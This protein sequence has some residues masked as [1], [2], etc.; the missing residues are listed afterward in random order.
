MWKAVAVAWLMGATVSALPAQDAALAAK[1]SQARQD[2]LSGHYQDA[3]AIYRQLVSALPAEPRLRLNL[4]LALVKAGEPNAA[5]PE[6]Q[7]VTRDDPKLGAAW[8][9]LGLAYA[10]L[11]R[12]REAISPLREAVRLDST[13]PQALF[14][15]ADAEL[16]SGAIEE[17]RRHFS[18][19]AGQKPEMAKAWEGLG[20]SY[21]AIS[22]HAVTD[23]KNDDA[24][25]AF[26]FALRGRARATNGDTA[27]AIQ[28]YKRA[29]G[30]D[31]RI[32]GL[33]AALASL[34]RESDQSQEAAKEDALEAEV[35]KP[36][37]HSVSAVCLY[38]NHDWA[39]V[40][41]QR[42][43][44]ASAENLYWASLAAGDL[45]QESFEHLSKLSASGEVHDL[46]AQA[47]QRSGKR[48]EAISEWRKA[49][50]LDP[51]NSR[52]QG[53][54]AESL[55]RARE[56]PEAQRLFEQLVKTEPENP[57]W[58]YFLGSTLQREDRDEEARPFLERAA[59]LEPDFL[60]AQENLGRVYLKLGQLDKA[61]VCLERAGPLDDD[62]SIA[63]ALSAAYRKLGRAEAARNALQKY[64]QLQQKRGT[65][66]P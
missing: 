57:D 44:Q 65:A 17:A 59:Q 31:P 56:Y 39:G 47:D 54:L 27:G 13:N 6:L 51:S 63:F 66:Q 15:L 41:S 8:F 61:V 5:I 46:L 28:L 10:Q 45:A 48:L 3:A 62:G 34:E 49:L 38:V 16:S 19:L 52:L 30:L 53:R 50:A 14:E 11:K 7:R 43:R 36:D 22:E 9:L 58:Q 60:P 32:P 2:M 1:S 21:L 37:C 18:M 40:L 4:A 12:P 20:L 42:E 25:S 29:I 24:D 33:H 35:K 55:L 26:W 23:L 64:Q